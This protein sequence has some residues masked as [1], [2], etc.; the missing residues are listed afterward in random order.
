LNTGKPGYKALEESVDS[1]GTIRVVERENLNERK[2]SCPI[3]DFIA[4]V[5]SI[6]RK[7]I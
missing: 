1:P 6:F 2:F 4:G 3:Q 5:R 7:K